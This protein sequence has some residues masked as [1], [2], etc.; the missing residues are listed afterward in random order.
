MTL[1]RKKSV[2]TFKS[3]KFAVR[4]FDSPDGLVARMEAV[5]YYKHF[6]QT[7][8]K[9]G[10]YG[11]IKVEIR[12]PKRSELQ[13]S[14]YW[15]YLGL[16]SVSSGHTPKEIHDWAKGKFLTTGILEI[17]GDKVRKMSSTTTLDRIEF[18]EY[19]ARI[20]QTTGVPVPD[21][22]PFNVGLTNAEYLELKNKQKREYESIKA[23]PL[24]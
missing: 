2:P 1:T 16:V 19:L 15:M 20:E 14:F 24:K 9:A 4:F 11:V 23:N 13:N 5:K 7:Y 22:E 10:D 3:E 6:L 21:P 12:K 18:G 8:A 17:F